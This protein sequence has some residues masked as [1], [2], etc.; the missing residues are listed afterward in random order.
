M[1][2]KYS[3]WAMASDVV[4]KNKLLAVMLAAAIAGSIAAVLLPPL[5]L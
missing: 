4:K 5:V 2:N 1:K 3:V